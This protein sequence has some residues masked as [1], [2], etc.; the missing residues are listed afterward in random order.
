MHVSELSIQAT[1]EILD[2]IEATRSVKEKQRLLMSLRGEDREVTKAL[3][4]QAA[5]WFRHFGIAELPTPST[6]IPG[7]T[8]HDYLDLVKSLEDGTC[9][10]SKQEISNFIA[11]FDPKE[12]KWLR[13]ALLK[14]L[15]CGLGVITINK[16]FP[17][18]AKTFS[19]QLA[20]T[21]EDPAL[22]QL[23]AYGQAKIDGV[24]AIC[25]VQGGRVQFLSRSGQ[26]Y[27]NCEKIEQEL[28][29][30][31]LPDCVF[32]GELFADNLP[33]TLSIVRTSVNDVADSMIERLKFF[34][35]DHMS[36][37]EWQSKSCK[38]PY[39]ERHKNLQHVLWPATKTRIE[40]IPIVLLTTQAELMDFYKEQVE[41]G[42]EGIMI[43]KIE[44]SYSFKR[45]P[46]WLKLKPIQ[47]GE[48]TCVDVY[49]GT[50]KHKGKLGGIVVELGNG[51]TC[52]VGS[53]FND[54]TRELF[55]KE[56]DK[57]VG[58]SC[59]IEYKWFTPDQRL[60]EPVY[61]RTREEQ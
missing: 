57:I 26:L 5:D 59:E 10:K 19:C 16:V 54:E 52:K 45:T 39:Y 9:T 1:A 50:G 35:F 41:A 53:G 13:R 2:Q 21:C 46:T 30:M 28:L 27:F 4:G 8:F 44:G 33:D 11:S 14:D 43:K 29:S 6:T 24:R 61:V 36:Y 55:W 20:D 48:F 38:V 12:S 25:F 22:V 49:E 7:V 51:I 31:N 32:D 18:L 23:P 47:T 37:N 34:V 3:L 58:K 56:R 15:R 40:V 42:S 60:R 17:G